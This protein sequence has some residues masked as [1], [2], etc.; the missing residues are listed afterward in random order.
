MNHLNYKIEFFSYW[1]TSSG[2][3]A[4]TASNLTVLK[5]ED[6]CPIIKGR[7]LKGMLRDAAD[8]LIQLSNGEVVS[9]DFINEVFGVGE[10]EASS[11]SDYAAAS[12]CFFTDAL[13]SE[14]VVQHAKKNRLQRHFYTTLHS[15]AI[16]EN[17][18]AKQ[19]SLRSLEVCVPLTLY[20]QIREFPAAYEAEMEC[21][22]QWVKR[23]GLNR[24]RGLGRC[25]FS[26]FQK[27]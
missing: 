4:G 23:M 7:T 20:A 16:A 26:T 18:I 6:N 14:A 21:C 17:G 27:A 8:N 19:H 3:A 22:F 5:D 12:S 15:T 10:E 9:E 2:L 1:H 24:H 13:L 11:K 25:Q